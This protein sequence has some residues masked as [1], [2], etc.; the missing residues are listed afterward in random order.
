MSCSENAYSAAVKKKVKMAPLEDIKHSTFINLNEFSK[1]IGKNIWGGNS[2][3]QIFFYEFW[4]MFQSN[5][6]LRFVGIRS[7][8]LT[9]EP[10]SKG[11]GFVLDQIPEWHH[12]FLLLNLEQSIFILLSSVTS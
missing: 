8:K 11:F 12:S 1:Y 7:S 3:P 5:Y 2:L 4:K 9:M 6:S 10:L